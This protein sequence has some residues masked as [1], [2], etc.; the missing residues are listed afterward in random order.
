MVEYWGG[1]TLGL[2]II[3]VCWG[4]GQALCPTHPFSGK[5]QNMAD[6]GPTQCFPAVQPHGS[7][8]RYKKKVFS[9]QKNAGEFNKTNGK[10][11]GHR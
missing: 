5:G 3:L 6:F 2:G 10:Q 1:L 8:T 9:C 7:S 4:G 11:I